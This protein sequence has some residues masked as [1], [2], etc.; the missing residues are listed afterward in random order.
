MTV[1]LLTPTPTLSPQTP[2]PK[3]SKFL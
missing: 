1:Q 2:H 3:I